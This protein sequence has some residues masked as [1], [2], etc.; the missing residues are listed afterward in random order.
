M[1]AFRFQLANGMTLTQQ[2]RGVN[3]AL[4]RARKRGF[5]VPVVHRHG[6]NGPVPIHPVR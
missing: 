6:A 3:D 5:V 2:G 1:R 4:K